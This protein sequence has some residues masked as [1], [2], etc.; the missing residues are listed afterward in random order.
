MDSHLGGVTGMQMMKTLG[1]TMQRPLSKNKLDVKQ[2]RCT[3]KK[4]TKVVT[5]VVPF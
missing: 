4:G 3:L 1:S 5:G 2:V